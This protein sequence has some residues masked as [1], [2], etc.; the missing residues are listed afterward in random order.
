[1]VQYKHLNVDTIAILSCVFA[2]NTKESAFMVTIEQICEY[3]ERAIAEHFLAGEKVGLRQMQTTAGV[4]MRA[5]EAVGDKDTAFR[6]RRIAAHAAN[7]LEDV[8]GE[9]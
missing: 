4:M 2:L 5:A 1:M 9:D 8:T 3:L 7:K 6:F